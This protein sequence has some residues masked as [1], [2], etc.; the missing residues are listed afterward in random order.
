MKGSTFDLFNL[1]TVFERMERYHDKG[2]EGE[3]RR[4]E[5]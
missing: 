1:G 2:R 5:L 4:N 3:D